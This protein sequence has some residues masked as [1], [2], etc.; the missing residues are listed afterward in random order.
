MNDDVVRHS[1]W[2]ETQ[3]A[4][5]QATLPSSIGLER[6]V[7][8]FL[9]CEVPAVIAAAREHGARDDSGPQVFAAL[10]EWKDHFR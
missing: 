8:P 7:N 6:R 4:A 1:A 9:R 5:G 2:C 10:R 3:R